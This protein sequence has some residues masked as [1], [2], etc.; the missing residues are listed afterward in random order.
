[1]CTVIA[2][3]VRACVARHYA[4]V[5]AGPVYVSPVAGYERAQ[6]H[7]KSAG[8]LALSAHDWEKNTHLDKKEQNTAGR[9][10]KH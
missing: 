2:A 9:P 7:E 8:A 1:M 6:Q 5:P 10:N 3:R 4:L